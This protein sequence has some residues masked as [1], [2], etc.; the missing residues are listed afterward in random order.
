[1]I[2]DF[3]KRET[4]FDLIAIIILWGVIIYSNSFDSPFQF[5]DRTFILQNP[6]IKHLNDIKSIISY[7]PQRWVAYFTFAVNYALSGNKVFSYHLFNLTIHLLNAILIYYF[8]RLILN[9]PS[10][11]I[12]RFQNSK[13][14]IPFFTSLLFLVHPVQT[15]AIT[16]IYQRFT[17]LATFFYLLTLIFYIRYR[18][19]LANYDYTGEETSPSQSKKSS[20]DKSRKKPKIK[21]SENLQLKKPKFLKSGIFYILCLLSLFLGMF[22]KEEMFTAPIMIILIDIYFISGFKV[23]TEQCSVPTRWKTFIPI[24]FTL[25]LIPLAYIFFVKGMTFSNINLNQI[26]RDTFIYSRTTYLLT[27]FNVLIKYL[28][29]FFFPIKLNLDYDFPISKTLFEYP[30]ILSFLIIFGLLIIGI[31]LYKKQRIISFGIIWFF[32]TISITSSILPIKDVIFEHRM[33][34]PSIGLSIALIFALYQIFPETVTKS[35]VSKKIDGLSSPCRD[36]IYHVSTRIG[37]SLLILLIIIAIAFSI[38]TY[39]RNEVWRDNVKLWED[40]VKKSPNKARVHNNLANALVRKGDLDMA[41]KHYLETLRI[42]P[43]SPETYNNLGIALYK[44]GKIDEAMKYYSDAIRLKPDYAEAHS[45]LGSAL[46]RNGKYDEAID[47]YYQAVKYNSQFAQV[48]TNIGNLVAREGRFDEAIANYS[49]TIE[50]DPDHSEAYNNWGQVLIQKGQVNEGIKKFYKAIQLDPEYVNAHF[51]LAFYL[52]QCGNTEEAITHYLE[53]IRINPDSAEAHNNL[54]TIL[55]RENRIKEA[56]AHFS[57]AIRINPDYV[58]AHSNLAENLIK[59]G[60]IEDAIK[61]LLEILRINPDDAQI[62]QKLGDVMFLQGK[63][64]D[65]IRYYRKAFQLSPDSH[66]IANKLAWSLATSEDAKL[67]N[68]DEAIKLA[69]FACKS[70][71]Y[72]DPILLDTLAAAYAEAKRFEEAIKTAQKALDLAQS[73]KQ[74]NIIKEIQNRLQLYKSNQPFREIHQ[75]TN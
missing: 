17:P 67:R 62:Y 60:K 56:N 41:I 20:Q 71:N 73:R 66:Y 29:L 9:L 51:N 37:G 33:Y 61:H 55:T 49:K 19:S 30:T 14:I 75:S 2:K 64:E 3:L 45:N 10:F 25:L 65:A 58:Q 63:S 4:R 31:I 50:L 40:T 23:G 27:Q 35:S 24:L 53:V 5:D 34:I 11:K 13:K 8:L 68:A 70:T 72:N 57:E 28:Q 1:M 69:E 42:V 48:Y 74:E 47:H 21:S 18:N 32:V 39:K 16:Y 54:G 44:Q 52:S 12:D 36:V 6:A 59:S 26:S 38:L 15:E 46:A 22:S 7:K 43:L